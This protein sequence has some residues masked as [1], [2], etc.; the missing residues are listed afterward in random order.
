M[1]RIYAYFTIVAK[2]G[3]VFYDDSDTVEELLDKCAI[4]VRAIYDG[5]ELVWKD[6]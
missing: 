1:K 5:K 2:D 4:P 6:K 3:R